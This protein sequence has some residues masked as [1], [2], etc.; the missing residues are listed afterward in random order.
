MTTL[1]MGSCVCATVVGMKRRANDLYPSPSGSASL[2][3]SHQH[4]TPWVFHGLLGAPTL[5]RE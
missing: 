5:L 1:P 4:S 2:C 3:V